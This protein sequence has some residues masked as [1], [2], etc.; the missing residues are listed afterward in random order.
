[1]IETEL[2]KLIQGKL[3]NVAELRLNNENLNEIPIQV[4]DLADNLELLDLNSNNIS[5]ISDRIV[6]L[7]KLKILFLSFNNFT[8]FPSI[9]STCPNLEMI[10]LKSNKIV[11]I[12]ENSFPHKLRWL[13]LTDNKIKKLPQ[14]IGNA[15]FLQKVML[16]GN[17]LD[18]LP[19]NMNNCRNI[20]LLR[21]SANN[22]SKIPDWLY[23]LPRLAWL[24]QSGNPCHKIQSINQ[25]LNAIDYQDIEILEKIGEGASGH[26]FKIKVKETQKIMALKIFKGNMT[27]DGLPESEIEAS[28]IVKDS[29]HLIK[30]IGKISNHPDNKTG[31][32]MEILPND[33]YNLGNPPNFETCTRDVFDKKLKYKL[34]EIILIITKITETCHHLHTNNILH[35]DVYAHNILVN[36]DNQIYLTD[37]GAASM[38]ENKNTEKMQKIEVRAWACLAEDL[39]QNCMKSTEEITDTEYFKTKEIIKKCF[40]IEVEKRPNFIEI[41]Q[42]LKK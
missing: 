9:L 18:S 40:S 36:K 11:E 25:D 38:Y 33:F 32:L 10:G 26:I 39:L 19:E 35:G 17:Q 37:F 41:I 29:P 5:K 14:S 34:S 30:I 16:A 2:E 1:M 42:L 13:I 3:A 28:L 21:I 20:E 4:Y 6:E 24:A 23:Q 31:I 12:A 7:K 8:E 15:N 22:F 27:S